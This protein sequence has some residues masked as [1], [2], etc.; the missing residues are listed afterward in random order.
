MRCVVAGAH[1]NTRECLG[2][3]TLPHS[4]AKVSQSIVNMS[5][6]IEKL[7]SLFME[8]GRSAP[9][10]QAIALCYPRSTKL[11]S[12]LSEYFIVVVGLC[13]HLFKFGQKSIVQQFTSTMNDSR[14]KVFRT[15]LEEWAKCIGEEASER[16]SRELKVQ[17]S[18]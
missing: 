11:Q 4:S 5:T 10:H 12:Y 1:A 2:V 9:R 15:E 6:Y 16:S 8:I 3:I 13:R 14:L 18:I 7:S 17:S